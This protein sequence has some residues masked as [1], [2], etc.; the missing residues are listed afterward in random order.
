MVLKVARM[1]EMNQRMMERHVDSDLEHWK[2]GVRVLTSDS[3]V[4]WK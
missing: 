4:S 1:K 3:H 2:R